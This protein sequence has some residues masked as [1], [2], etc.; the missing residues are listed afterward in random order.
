[1]IKTHTSF[2]GHVDTLASEHEMEKRRSFV[3]RLLYLYV[4]VFYEESRW[5]VQVVYFNFL[6]H[7]PKRMSSVKLKL[8]T[9]F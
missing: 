1:M 2:P 5:T 6:W 7:L 9:K 4:A 3:S 8:R